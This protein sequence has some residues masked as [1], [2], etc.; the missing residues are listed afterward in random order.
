LSLVFFEPRS[1]RKASEE[2]RPAFFWWYIGIFGGLTLLTIILTVLSQLYFK[3]RKYVSK[4][5]ELNRNLVS[6]GTDLEG[7]TTQDA[8]TNANDSNLLV[9]K[10]KEKKGVQ[11]EIKQSPKNQTAP[12]KTL[13]HSMVEAF[14]FVQRMPTLMVS[15][16]PDAESGAFDLIRNI[17]MCWVILAHQFSERLQKNAEIMNMAYM[18]DTAKHDWVVT[19]IEHG[20]Y[21]VDFF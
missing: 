3:K 21:A 15:K 7:T 1:V 2:K 12:Q 16:R 13:C 18:I 6:D 9:A 11:D 20:F 19:F 8:T 5:P 4:K 17:S 10:P 14:D